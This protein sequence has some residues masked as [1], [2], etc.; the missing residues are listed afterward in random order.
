VAHP[1]TGLGKGH[2]WDDNQDGKILKTQEV[3]AV[4]RLGLSNTKGPILPRT[5]ETIYAKETQ[6]LA[7][8][9]G[10]QDPF[11]IRK[12]SLQKRFRINLPIHGK[13]GQ[14]RF[15]LGP[16]RRTLYAGSGF[17][18]FRTKLLWWK[19]LKALFHRFP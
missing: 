9:F 6:V 13:V 19:G 17:D 12:G 15:V 10:D 8:N 1:F 18:A 7:R 2:S 5:G 3:I 16:K 11:P 14:D 4:I